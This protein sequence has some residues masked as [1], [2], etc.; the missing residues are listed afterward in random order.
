MTPD[1]APAGRLFAPGSTRPDPAWLDRDA[2][3]HFLAWVDG[4]AAPR[5]LGPLRGLT[6]RVSG[7]ARRAEFGDG[8]AFVTEDDE[9]LDRLVGGLAAAGRRRLA[10]FERPNWRNLALLLGGLLLLVLGVRLGLPVM[11]DRAAMAVPTALEARIGAMVFAQMDGGVFVPS[12]LPPDRQAALQ[13]LFARVAAAS[14]LDGPPPALLLRASRQM[15]ANAVAFPGGPVVITDALVALAPSDAALAGVM[16]HELAHVRERHGLRQAA[17]A[18]SVLLM[19]ALVFGDAG[20]MIDQLAAAFGLV[21][22]NAYS[23]D[24]E[25]EADQ[26]AAGILRGLGIPTEDLAR[27]L[28]RLGMGEAEG[29]GWLG[30]HPE[31][32]ERARELRTGR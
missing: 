19:V 22:A 6:Q 18:G 15:G 20:S 2:D 12:T 21:V 26:I 17:R 16:A 7:S 31:G 28:E 4:E 32:A 5:L 3:G 24:F 14:D 25:R 8:V 27:L 1:R 30:T 23:R 10:W 29:L 11:A 9:A 13:G